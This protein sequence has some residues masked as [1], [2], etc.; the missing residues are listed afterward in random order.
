[1]ILFTSVIEYV[2]K[3]NIDPYVFFSFVCDK[4]KSFFLSFIN[5]TYDIVNTFD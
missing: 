2:R 1:M 4:K 3:I 5:T